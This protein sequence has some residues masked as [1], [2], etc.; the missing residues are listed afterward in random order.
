MGAKITREASGSG[1]IISF[2]AS[3][4][5][6]TASAVNPTFT[7]AVANFADFGAFGAFAT[8]M[9]EDD[10]VD[11]VATYA[12]IFSCCDALRTSACLLNLSFAS[13]DKAVQRLP[14]VAITS[15][16]DIVGFDALNGA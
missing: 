2:I 7:G 14:R 10:E 8:T 3:T 9:A 5:G 4:I 11:F 15:A 12:A 6:A 1:A 13:A 16:C